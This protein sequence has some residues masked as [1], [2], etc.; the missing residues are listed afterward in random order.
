MARPREYSMAQIALAK[1]LYQKGGFTLKQIADFVGF[2]TSGMVLYYCKP[3]FKMEHLNRCR[4]YQ[5]K[6]KDQINDWQRVYMR[7]W[8][9]ENKKKK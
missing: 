2:S 7:K 1:Q 6:H 3:D 5:N 8:L 4:R 9:E